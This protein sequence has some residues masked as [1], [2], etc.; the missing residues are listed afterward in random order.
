MLSVQTGNNSRQTLLSLLGEK[1]VIKKPI[2]GVHFLFNPR[3]W[4]LALFFL[5]HTQWEIKW[6]GLMLHH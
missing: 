2:K 5:F 1:K 4:Y 3:F 6:K